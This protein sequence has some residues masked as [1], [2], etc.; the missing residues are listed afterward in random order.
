VKQYDDDNDDNKLIRPTWAVG[1]LFRGARRIHINLVCIHITFPSLRGQDIFV[2][3]R[4]HPVGCQ[5]I[6]QGVEK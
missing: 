6:P 4:K 2:K 3:G 1:A 5:Q